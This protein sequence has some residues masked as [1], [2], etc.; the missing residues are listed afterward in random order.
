MQ[1]I[2][3]MVNQIEKL[4][5]EI[6]E[7][8]QTIAEKKAGLVKKRD[9]MKGLLDAEIAKEAAAQL[10]GNDYGCGTATIETALHKIKVTVSK[11]VKWNES[12]LHDIKVLIAAANKNPADYIKEK[13]SVSETD[14]KKFPDDI[15][16]V[17]EPARSV[18]PSAPKIE[19]ISK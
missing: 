2:E 3:T 14:Y 7:L 16:A 5:R 12:K 13:L 10:K 11:K 17:F 18:E 9:E 8:E 4:D 6:F 1:N 15:Q 19:I